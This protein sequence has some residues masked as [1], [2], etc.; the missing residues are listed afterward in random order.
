M[1]IRSDCRGFAAQGAAAPERK[2]SGGMSK[3]EIRNQGAEIS[4]RIGGWLWALYMM[5]DVLLIAAIE[6]ETFKALAGR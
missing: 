5:A 4:A 1:G 3:S 6:F 2:G